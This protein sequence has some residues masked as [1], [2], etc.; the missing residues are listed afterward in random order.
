[1]IPLLQSLPFITSNMVLLVMSFYRSQEAPWHL[2]V[3]LLLQVFGQLILFRA[4]L[5]TQGLSASWQGRFK[6]F[7]MNSFN[8]LSWRPWICLKCG[9]SKAVGYKSGLIFWEWL[10]P[11]PWGY[12][13]RPPWSFMPP[14]T[15]PITKPTSFPWKWLYVTSFGSNRTACHGSFQS[16]CLNVIPLAPGHPNNQL[17]NA[18]SSRGDLL[19]KVRNGL[20]FLWNRSPEPK[21]RH[22]SLTST[23]MWVARPWGNL[24]ESFPVSIKHSSHHAEIS[25]LP[26][27]V[28]NKESWNSSSLVF[29]APSTNNGESRIF[30]ISRIRFHSRE[31]LSSEGKRKSSCQPPNHRGWLLLRS[32]RNVQRTFDTKPREKEP[33]KNIARKS[34][35]NRC[36]EGY[37]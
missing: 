11:P 37:C 6:K 12:G 3:F 10:I 27:Q 32:L 5:W 22:L 35:M 2:C 25:M 29:P 15:K 24:C 4:Q 33:Y 1:M 34:L 26:G 31:L 13:I 20:T 19:F 17:L 30:W 28:W 8:T 23:R 18:I 7:W 36:N 16:P 9:A 14:P 21:K